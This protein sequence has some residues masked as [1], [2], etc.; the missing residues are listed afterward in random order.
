MNLYL[1]SQKTNDDYDTYDS[2]VVVSPDEDTARNIHPL[3]GEIINWE[4][5]KKNSDLDNWCESPNDV[6]VKLIGISIEGLEQGV[7]CASYRAG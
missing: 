7:V 1:I 5:H 2:A 6:R 4:E 3:N